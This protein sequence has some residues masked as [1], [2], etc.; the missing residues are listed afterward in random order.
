MKVAQ[1]R[2]SLS[3]AALALP[4]FACAAPQP[5]PQG[6][7]PVAEPI[8]PQPT[9]AFAVQVLGLHNEERAEVGAPPLQWDPA[10]AAA[11][12]SYADELTR[13]GALRHSARENRPGQ[14]ENLWMGTRRG[15]TPWLMVGSWSSEKS[16]F[17]PGIFPDVSTTGN[18]VTVGHYTQMI[19]RGTTR[20]GCAI[21]SSARDDFLVC[22]YAPAGNVMGMTVP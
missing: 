5:A 13:I 3:C 1:H 12:S 11:A 22:R 4:L 18:W 2:S 17:R 7:L 21:R 16:R 14:G 20:L 10:L 8:L 9:D 15:F 19:W 6:P